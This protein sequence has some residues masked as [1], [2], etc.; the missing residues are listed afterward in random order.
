MEKFDRQVRIWGTHGQHIIQTSH[1]CVIG[2]SPVAC[3]IVKNLALPGIGRLTMVAVN[4]TDSTDSPNEQFWDMNTWNV[5]QIDWNAETMS[6][7][8]FWKSFDLIIITTGCS[9]VLKVFRQIKSP[10]SLLCGTFERNGFVTF[11]SGEPHFVVESHQKHSIPDLRLGALR[12]DLSQFYSSFNI[13]EESF[14]DLPF[15]ALLYHVRENVLKEKKSHQPICRD[16]LKRQIIALQ[17]KVSPSTQ[18]PNFVEALRFSHLA[19][20]S[21]EAL[22]ENVIRCLGLKDKLC[23]VPFNRDVQTLLRALSLYLKSPQSEGQLPLSGV[24]PDMES[25]Y[26]FYTALRKAYS[27]AAAKDVKLLS[28]HVLQEGA[29]IAVEKIESFCRNCRHI[30]VIEPVGSLIDLETYL[31]NEV[32]GSAEIIKSVFRSGFSKKPDEEERRKFHP[33]ISFVAG[34]AA[35]EATKVLTHQ[36]LPLHN[37]LVYE[38]ERG[39]LSSIKIKSNQ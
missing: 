34:I 31:S 10:P 37:T 14:P 11:L 25:N 23:Q 38:G 27:D 17:K 9:D 3:E 35:Q 24:I 12:G 5:T 1:V 30:D 8:W 21:I 2:S 7:A 15:A 32:T 20:D 22:P 6:S 4:S 36:F 18:T 19:S 28:E 26:E 33:C 29:P 13:R 39:H 16:D